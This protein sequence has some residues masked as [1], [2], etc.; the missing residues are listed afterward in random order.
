MESASF[1]AQEK[2][3]LS[4]QKLSTAVVTSRSIVGHGGI[5][6][7]ID[8]CQVGN[9]ISQSTTTA[10]LKNLLTMPEVRQTLVDEG[11]VN[12]M[13]NVL[14]Y[15]VVLGLK[16]QATECLLQLTSGTEKFR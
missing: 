11:I 10:T 12:V 15:D 7:L 8:L 14:D 2:V 9:S 6:P 3:V 4:I 5:P 1:V 16:E 13:I